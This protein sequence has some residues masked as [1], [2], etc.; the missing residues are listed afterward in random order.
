MSI[1]SVKREEAKPG[2]EGS[3]KSRCKQQNDASVPALLKVFH[4][5]TIPMLKKECTAETWILATVATN[6]LDRKRCWLYRIFTGVI[7]A[8]IFIWFCSIGTHT[9]PALQHYVNC[10]VKSREAKPGDEGSTIHYKMTFRLLHYWNY[11]NSAWYQSSSKIGQRKQAFRPWIA[12]NILDCERRRPYEISTGA[13]LARI[14]I[15]SC[16]LGTHT[17]STRSSSACKAW[18]EKKPSLEMKDISTKSRCKQ[19]NDI[20]APALLKWF[21]FRTIPMLKKRVHSR[22][23]TFI[24][25]CHLDRKRC[26][27]CGISI[28]AKLARISYTIL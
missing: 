22:N 21:H 11:R 15:W 12:T 6:L 13:K 16:N 7:L 26:C 18:S 5:R 17:S 23:M 3:T 8:R 9:S 4:F 14:F 1:Q 20:S 27:Q 10:E 19:R 2:D 24:Y 25:G 28:G